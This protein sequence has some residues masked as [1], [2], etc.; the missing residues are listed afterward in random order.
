[1]KLKSII[2]AGLAAVVLSATSAFALSVTVDAINQAAFD[3]LD[4]GDSLVLDD[5]SFSGGRTPVYTSVSGVYRSPWDTDSDSDSD[6]A[7]YW[8]SGVSGAPNAPNPALLVFN[9]LR[10]SLTFLWGS[11]DIYNHLTFFDDNGNDLGTVSGTQVIGLGASQGV[12]A[13]LVTISGFNNGFL[14][15]S[16]FS[17][18]SNAFEFSSITSVPNSID[19]PA[20]PI[21]AALPLFG[22][23][24]A[25]MG[26]IGW[27]RKH[28]TVSA[29]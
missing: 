20:V 15:A 14:K 19:P 28:K 16:F 7:G 17:Q 5:G 22:T 1:M 4:P 10:D 9:A 2:V 11:V 12:G 23:G 27:R 21:P 25:L 8:T 6:N 26:F 18:G 24:I 3:S 13:A 29:A